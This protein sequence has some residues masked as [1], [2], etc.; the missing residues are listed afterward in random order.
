MTER[1][2]LLAARKAWR[3][4]N[5]DEL[6]WLFGEMGLDLDDSMEDVFRESLC[7]GKNFD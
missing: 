4:G 2:R 1:E 6:R 5:L 7:A 3:E